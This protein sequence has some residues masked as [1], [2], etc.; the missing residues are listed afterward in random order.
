MLNNDSQYEGQTW[1]TIIL[2]HHFITMKENYTHLENVALVE[3]GV[4]MVCIQLDT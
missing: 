1:V 4:G 3:A 2:C